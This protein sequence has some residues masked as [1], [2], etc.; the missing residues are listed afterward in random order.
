MASTEGPFSPARGR[1]TLSLRYVERYAEGY[2]EQYP[3]PEQ[4]ATWLEELSEDEKGADLVTLWR[5]E[6][7]ALGE[8]GVL[9]PLDQFAGEYG[10]DFEREFFSP[11]LDLFRASGAL[12]ALP[13]DAFPLMLYYDSDYFAQV[14]VAPPDGNWDWD[15]LVEN[16]L[17][18]TQREEDGTVSRW[19]LAAHTQSSILSGGRCGRT[20][21]RWLDPL[22]SQCRLQEL[23]AIEALEF[24]RGLMHTH[25]VSPAVFD[26]DLWRLI[27]D[28]AGSPPAMV[29]TTIPLG[30][31]RFN[32]RRAE[33]PRGKA[34]SV[35]FDSHSRHSNCRA[36]RQ[37]GSSLH[38]AEG[39]S[40]YY[41]TV[42][43]RTRRERGGGAAR[44][45][46]DGPPTGGG[47]CDTAVYGAWPRLAVGCGAVSRHVE[48]GGG[49]R[50]WRR[51]GLRGKLGCSILYENQRT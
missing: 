16:A 45:V 51:R 3:T 42:C 36:D 37:A 32:Y 13:A 19:G 1:Y 49:A 6:A 12:Y 30:S 14:G 39:H 29:Y 44:S 10:S 48:H 38:S 31:S 24:F 43:Q 28:P 47:H 9:L 22:M 34:R 20:K 5:D 21:R 15:V 41:G 26:M 33:L 40:A 27:D 11:V 35:P 18:L 46:P 17:K 2:A 7:R 50:A 23:A 8:M 25:G 4:L